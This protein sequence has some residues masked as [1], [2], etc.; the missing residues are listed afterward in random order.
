MA[1]RRSFSPRHLL[2]GEG[3]TR[4]MV[5]I[6]ML[7]ADQALAEPN[8]EDTVLSASIEGMDRDDLR[9]LGVLVTWIGIHHPW[10]N[11]DRLVR[12]VMECDRERVRAFW[13]SVAHWLRSDRRFARMAHWSLKHRI[14]LLRTGSEFQVKRRGED[15]RFAGSPLLVP[16]GVLRDRPGDVLSPKELAQRHRT[17]RCRVLMGPS[18]RADMWALLEAEPSLTAAEL[19]RRAYGSFATAWQVKKDYEL[20]AA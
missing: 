9:A 18:Y 20:L 17:Y 19:A 12:I 15:D 16:A 14:P 4:A 6:G 1:Y 11:A 7:F 10:L 8:I 5:G 13:A 3:L 2:E